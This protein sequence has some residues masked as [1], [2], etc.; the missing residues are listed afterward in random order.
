MEEIKLV[1]SRKYEDKI[2]EY[3]LQ[4]IERH[5]QEILEKARK[6]QEYKDEQSKQNVI[7]RLCHRILDALRVK[8]SER[9]FINYP[10]HTI[11]ETES[12]K[13]EIAYFYD[14]KNK[15][16]NFDNIFHLQSDVVESESNR[17][18]FKFTIRVSDVINTIVFWTSLGYICLLPFMATWLIIQECISG[19]Y[20][21]N[22]IYMIYLIIMILSVSLSLLLRKLKNK[23][24]TTQW[25]AARGA[26]WNE[27]LAIL[28]ESSGNW[29]RQNASKILYFIVLWFSVG[30][31]FHVEIIKYV[32]VEVIKNAPMEYFMLLINVYCSGWLI[33]IAIGLF[34]SPLGF[35][36]GSMLV[37]AILMNK[38]LWTGI[39]LFVT[40][41]NT[42]LTE[43]FWMLKNFQEVPKY[44]TNPTDKSLKIIKSNILKYKVYTSIGVIIIYS[45]IHLVD[46]LHL[47]SRVLSWLVEMPDMGSQFA[48]SFYQLFL[49]LVDRL[50]VISVF[51]FILLLIKEIYFSSKEGWIRGKIDVSI[52]SLYNLIYQDV[53]E[54]EEPNIKKKVEIKEKVGLSIAYL[55]KIEPIQ[56]LENSEALPKGIQVLVERTY[57]PNKRKVIVIMPDL[58]VH[59]GIVEFEP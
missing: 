44:I 55:D 49:N 16:L 3:N 19:S 2:K 14:H 56:L 39:T 22:Y 46:K 43:E 1:K 47:Y 37:A 11:Q 51:I 41:W 5:E 52:S 21:P 36:I 59:S 27:K 26:K 23:V 33:W 54:V 53:N 32:P 42:L 34:K 35:S 13:W 9:N 17:K 30:L 58:T 4:D 29:V 24:K 38:N 57:D 12:D 7:I 15:T 48:Y 6:Y 50:L 20:I 31:V 18:L 28:L 45:L 10:W 40:L 25:K 8:H